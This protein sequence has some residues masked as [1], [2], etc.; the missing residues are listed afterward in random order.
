ME[1]AKSAEDGVNVQV[2]VRCRYE[3]WYIINIVEVYVYKRGA[4]Y[5]IY[6]QTA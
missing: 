4:L 3:S 1:E 2:V 6:R 5:A